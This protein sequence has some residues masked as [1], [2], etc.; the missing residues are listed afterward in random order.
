MYPD[1]EV[2]LV[3]EN[4]FQA[5]ARLLKDIPP[6]DGC[7]F[8]GI[9]LLNTLPGQEGL[10]LHAGDSLLYLVDTPSGETRRVTTNNFWLLGRTDRFHQLEQVSLCASS[11]LL[12]A[13]D[14]FAALFASGGGMER[15]LG[16]IF[17]QGNVEEIPDLLFDLYDRPKEGLDDA[18]VLCLAP[19]GQPGNQ[20]A[21]IL[22]GTS[23]EEER[24][25][26]EA[27]RGHRGGD[28]Y[29][30]FFSADEGPLW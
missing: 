3:R 21:I 5:S 15:V 30:E 23:A 24:R 4:L 7:T 20:P 8:T 1:E 13:T 16:E 29:E 17:P 25:R 19:A 12:L 10:L 14:G 9:L 2:N 27:L 11:R 22:G 26:G 28:C 18:A 6:G